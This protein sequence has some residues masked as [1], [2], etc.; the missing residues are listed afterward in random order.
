MATLWSDVVQKPQFQ[1]LSDQQKLEA[2]TQYF[3]EVVAPQVP[4]EEKDQAKQQFFTEY[5]YRPEPEAGFVQSVQE[6]FS[7]K[8]KTT[9]ELESLPLI[10]DSPE[11]NDVFSGGAWKAGL[12]LL[13]TGDV[14]QQ[15][16][17]IEENIDGA[18]FREDEKGNTIAMLPTG[19]YALQKPGLSTVDVARAFVQSAP[20]AKVGQLANIGSKAAL[21]SKSQ[22]LQKVGGLI[23]EKLAGAATK[24]PVLSKVGQAAAEGAAVATGLEA[25]KAAVGGEVELGNILLE[26]GLSGI[27]EAVPAVIKAWKGR[28]SKEAEKLT[29][30]AATIEAE[31]IGSPLSP[32][33]G[34]ARQE[35]LAQ[36]ISAAA[37]ETEKSTKALQQGEQVR[38]LAADVEIDPVAEKAIQDVFGID[39]PSL[40]WIVKGEQ[41]QQLIQ[42]L[43]SVIGSKEGAKQAE[44][45]VTV[46]NSADKF[47][48]DFG[49]TLD[50]YELGQRVKEGVLRNIDDLKDKSEE[51]YAK[52]KVPDDFEVDVSKIVNVL[53]KDAKK[54]KSEKHLSSFERKILQDFKGRFE[55]VKSGAVG[56]GKTGTEKKYVA[57]KP[58][59][60]LVDKIRKDIGADLRGKSQVFANVPEASLKR[61]YGL[62]SDSQEK[63][64]VAYSPE[65][66]NYWSLGKEAVKKRK[67]L[68][69]QAIFLAGK[70]LMSDI[71]PKIGRELRSA[72]KHSI[73][74]FHKYMDAVPD[75]LKGEVIMTAMNDAFTL[76]TRRTQLSLPGFVDWYENMIRSPTVKKEIEQYM[77]KGAA[78]R[79]NRFYVA[80]RAIRGAMG[81]RIETGK[82]TTL[83]SKFDDQNGMI[84]NLYQ[85]AGKAIALEAIAAPF[86]AG[87]AGTVGAIVDHS[88]KIKG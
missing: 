51:Y 71:M 6:A 22:Q 61:M 21:A 36:S 32:E 69:E 48:E 68:E 1:S 58:T 46:Y 40:G 25:T 14:D 30:E 37:R 62:L 20:F 50:K 3:N 84:A 2:Q 19:D 83:L 56:V 49:G 9:E 28:A 79:L 82:L 15:K 11:M 78:Q 45:L 70:D 31:R 42:G 8:G 53:E 35:G 52:A 29:G 87:G 67:G 39:N 38:K 60:A 4:P 66:A 13:L 77:P 65:A 24:A 17:I 57:S 76:G 23:G 73:S 27:P 16:S 10:G 5:N 43:A 85:T 72:S 75:D 7:G 64:T 26:A 86:G 18:L 74:K 54:F 63:A 88:F 34:Q 33:A 41:P 55:T 81:K 12:G 47:I 80:S 44:D 59:Y